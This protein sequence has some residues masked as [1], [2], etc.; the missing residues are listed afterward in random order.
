MEAMLPPSSGTVYCERQDSP[1][2]F[3]LKTWKLKKAERRHKC[4]MLERQRGSASSYQH[5]QS[6]SI[7]CG[8]RRKCIK[9]SLH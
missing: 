1:R 4:C 7:G 9:T 8:E 3:G 5:A 2:N 6:L